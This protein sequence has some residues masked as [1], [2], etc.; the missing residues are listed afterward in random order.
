MKKHHFLLGFLIVFL[1]L[2]IFYISNVYAT[3]ANFGYEI[4]G[5]SSTATSTRA[6]KCL[7]TLTE[8][9]IANTITI[10]VQNSGAF[11]YD[12]DV[13][14][15]SGLSLLS[16]LTQSI[17][18]SY[19]NWKVFDI[20]DVELNAGVY[21]LA[22]K[23]IN[24][25]SYLNVYYNT[26]DTNQ[27]AYNT[28]LATDS[29]PNPFVITAYNSR[30][31]SIYCTY[32]ITEA[33]T[34]KNFYGTIPE[35]FS[36][37]T[38]KA[39]TFNRFGSVTMTFTLT[40]L[41]KF[42]TAQTLNFYGTIPFTFTLSTSYIQSIV[43]TFFGTIPLTFSLTSTYNYWFG[44]LLNF[45]GT[46]PLTFT[47]NLQ[48]LISFNLY[49]TIPLTFTIQNLVK[50]WTGTLL[51]L[52]GTIPFQFNILTY[53]TSTIPTMDLTFALAALAF[54]LAITLGIL[55]LIKRD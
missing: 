26:G 12:L 44:T 43:K 3:Q 17:S 20:P 42:I 36:V 19:D 49:S 7:F 10:Y 24:S 46:I 22:F 45:Y 52:F 35:T 18:A 40:S 32:T 23:F 1:V 21:G 33:G 11:D 51:Y 8:N 9:G 53:L 34:T 29:L 13:G 14:I 27:S 2:P 30:K 37:A 39:W 25:G 55:G 47:I 15:Y 48:K 16:H 41:I 38:Q 50:Y 4:K 5:S 31:Y 6:N 28:I 54:I